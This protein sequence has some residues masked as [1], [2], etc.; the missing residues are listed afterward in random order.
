[1]GFITTVL[2][3]FL[4]IFLFNGA[5]GGALLLS[6]YHFSYHENKQLE[7]NRQVIYKGL[8]DKGKKDGFKSNR[9]TIRTTAK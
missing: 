4:G 3:A 5:V 9:R 2:A 7:Y 6:C 8:H 1:M